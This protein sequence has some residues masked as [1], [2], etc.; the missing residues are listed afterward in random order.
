VTYLSVIIPAYNEEKRIGATLASIHAFFSGKK[1]DYE[2]IVVDDGSTDTTVRQVENSLLARAGRL[3]VIGNGV[4]RGKGFSIKN[5]IL[6]SSGEYVLFSDADMSTPIEECDRFLDYAKQGYDI[7][8]GSRSVSGAEIRIRQP[9]YREM[10]GKI[11]NLFVKALLGMKFNDT[12]CGFKLFNAAPA[13][14]IASL[15]K[16]DGFSFDVEMLY[17]AKTKGYKIMETGVIWNNSP[18]SK[19]MVMNS[20]FNMFLSLFRIKRLHG[21]V[22]SINLF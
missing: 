3:K 19:V 5:G 18:L 21:R 6:N 4:N 11:F 13:K 20:S 8:I 1:Y 9:L 2:I 7:V 16:I 12:Q 14:E 10:M 15:M 17:L 22:P